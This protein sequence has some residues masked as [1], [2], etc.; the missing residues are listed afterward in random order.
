MSL[1]ACGGFAALSVVLLVCMYVDAER[2]ALEFGLALRWVTVLSMTGF[3]MVPVLFRHVPGLLA[4]LL[5]LAWAAQVILLTILP[6]QIAS[7]LPVSLLSVTARGGMAYGIGAALGSAITSIVLNAF[8]VGVYAY[9]VVVAIACLCLTVAT[10]FYPANDAD[11]S[12]LGMETVPENE[13]YAHRL[14]RRSEE[15]AERWGLTAR[16]NEVLYELVLGKTRSTIASELN[17]SEET[18]KTHTKHIYE[19]LG[20]HSLRELVI[21]VESGSR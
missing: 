2:D 16:E 3:L 11:A 6:A 1:F 8:G 13:P 21:L 10:L 9:S 4:F 12:M 19:R 17:I 7:K 20:V 18:V 15:V 14:K 5:A